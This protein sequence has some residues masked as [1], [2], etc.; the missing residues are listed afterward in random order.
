MATTGKI[1]AEKAKTPTIYYLSQDLDFEGFNWPILN[2]AN[3]DSFNQLFNGN[4]HTISNVTIEGAADGEKTLTLNLFYKI[5]YGTLMNFKFDNI[6]IT[7]TDNES[8]NYGKQVGVVGDLQ[9]GY[10]HNIRITRFK[11]K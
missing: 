9:N 8:T 10:L 5:S 6:S 3:V 4:N 1:G 7:S 11:G 2:K